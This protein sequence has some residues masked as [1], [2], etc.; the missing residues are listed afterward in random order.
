MTKALED[1]FR[2]AEKLP[3]REQDQLAAAIRAEIKAEHAWDAKLAA[4]GSALGKL[5]D[6]ALAEHRSGPAARTP[7]GRVLGELRAKIVGP[8]APGLS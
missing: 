4:S 1:A 3:E 8:G 2:E 6:E 5:A 7:L